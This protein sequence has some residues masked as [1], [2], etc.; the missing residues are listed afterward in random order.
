M[1][2]DFQPSQQPEKH[3]DGKSGD[4]GGKPP[5]AE[6]IVN[7]SPLQDSLLA[8]DSALVQLL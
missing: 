6:G 3:N 5:A 2:L 4:D 1:R 8:Q 7:L